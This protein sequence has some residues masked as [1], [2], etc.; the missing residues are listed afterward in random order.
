MQRV[1]LSM[2]KVQLFSAVYA[3][4]LPYHAVLYMQ[5]ARIVQYF[6]Q[7]PYYVVPYNIM[8]VLT[9]I[10]FSTLYAKCPYCLVLYM[11]GVISI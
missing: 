10:S 6:T 8:C 5:R 2:Q 7:C 1:V 4:R 9:A 11:Q 3:K